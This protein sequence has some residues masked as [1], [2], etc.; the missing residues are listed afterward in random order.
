MEHRLKACSLPFLPEFWTSVDD[1][2][3]VWT[4]DARRQRWN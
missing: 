3:R 2:E 1:G 4:T